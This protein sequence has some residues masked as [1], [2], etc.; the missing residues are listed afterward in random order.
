[1]KYYVGVDL[2]TTSV[3][4][5]AFNAQGGLLSECI[6]AY[7]LEQ[8]TAGAAEQD[9]E[10]VFLAAKETLKTVVADMGGA[11]EGIGLSTAMHSVVLLDGDYQPLTPIITWA[12]TRAPVDNFSEA[13]RHHFLEYT[14]TPV[15]PMSPLV[16]LPWLRGS[17]EID[18]SQV[19]Y[20]GD[21]KSCLVNRWSTA[22]F[23][24][25]TNL[26]SA[27]GLYHLREARWYPKAL[28]KAGVST[29]QLPKVVSPDHPLPWRKNVA[30]QIG[31]DPNT[32]FFI[33]GSDGCLAN[34][35][36]GILGNHKVALTIGTSGAIRTTHKKDRVDPDLG[37]FN[38]HLLEDL[39]VLGGASNN[40]G[41]TLEWLYS[42]LNHPYDS[43]GALIEAAAEANPDGLSFQPYLFGER[44]PIYDA[45][46]S[47]TLKGMRAHHQPAQYA[48]A[49]LEG[50]TDNLIAILKKLEVETGEIE[51]LVASGGFTRSD[52]WLDLFRERTGRKIT[53]ADTPQSSAY[54]AALV[55]RIGIG[56][57]TLQQLGA[58]R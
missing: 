27:T 15:H 53:V 31:I 7:P 57:I 32:P 22:G 10:K 21:L 1:M 20:V 39:Y 55:A 44:A 5:C 16:K 2:G 51:E 33:G 34:L 13:E 54:G 49:V 11:P 43:I 6:R 30:D 50:V 4:S 12:D 35:G 24:L 56:E 3:K 25:D 17:K 18:W 48:R 9:P 47:A 28:D 52:F 19:K 41:K 42:W 37:L 58:A 45:K 38:Y 14:G 46:A 29:D 40:G 26:A 36:S 8:P 23:L